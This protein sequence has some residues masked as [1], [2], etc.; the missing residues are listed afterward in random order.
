MV[1]QTYGTLPVGRATG[2][3]EDT[4]LNY[5]EFN[6]NGTGFKFHDISSQALYNTIG[7][8]NATWF[9]RP[10]HIRGM[11]E[12]AMKQNYSWDK[13]SLEYENLY[14]SMTGVK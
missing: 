11:R 10:N 6:G 13:S 5:N 7:W 8:A 3:L 2:G 12:L 9:D 4:I 1:S 14:Q